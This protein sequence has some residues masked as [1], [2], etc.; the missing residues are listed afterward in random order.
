M[1]VKVPPNVEVLWVCVNSIGTPAY[2]I[3]AIGVTTGIYYPAYA[4]PIFY[5][6]GQ[7]NFAIVVANCLDNEVNV[8]IHG[9]PSSVD[10]WVI[11]ESSG[12]FVIDTTVDAV[13]AQSGSP[14][15]GSGLVIA[16]SD[17]TDTRIIATDLIGRVIPLVP[18][19]TT[20]AISLPTTAAQFLATPSSGENYLFGAD[21]RNYAASTAIVN[22]TDAAGDHIG[23]INVAAGLSG[24]LDL[25]GYRI[26]GAVW[27]STSVANVYMNIRFANAQ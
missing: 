10:W 7:T 13:I 9:A 17:G 2:N 20:G 11:A 6:S 12:R 5:S 24:S 4:L 18:S 22:I 15:P 8:Q 27:A 25:Q 26:A 21:V 1:T 14:T 3:T 23:S 19:A 16:G